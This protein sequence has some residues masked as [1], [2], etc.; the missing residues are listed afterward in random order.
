MR[1]L[2]CQNA[3]ATTQ[4]TSLIL[5]VMGGLVQD[6][7]GHDERTD[8]PGHDGT[9]CAYRSKLNGSST[10]CLNVRIQFAPNAPS[11]TR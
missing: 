9:S 4:P 2:P 5:A 11:A 8:R 10:T 7:P 6:R 1:L 3:D